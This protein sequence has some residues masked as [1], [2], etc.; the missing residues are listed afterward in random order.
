[1]P[2]LHQTDRFESRAIEF[3]PSNDSKFDRAE[4]LCGIPE[5]MGHEDKGG[6]IEIPLLVA[7]LFLGLDYLGSDPLS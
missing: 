6:F 5:C 1:M 2:R 3:S 7:Q 4:C